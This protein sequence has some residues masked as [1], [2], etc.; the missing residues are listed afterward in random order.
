M[1]SAVSAVL[2]IGVVALSTGLTACGGGGDGGNSSVAAV[3]PDP[4]TLLDREATT[5]GNSV[6]TANGSYA[7]SPPNETTPNWAAATNVEA[8][9]GG[10]SQPGVVVSDALALESTPLTTTTTVAAFEAPPDAIS[11]WKFI[12]G[13][14]FPGAMGSLSQ[15]L[16]VGGGNAARIDYD[17]GCSTQTVALRAGE[18][19]GKYVQMTLASLTSL[20]VSDPTTAV[21][22]F[23]TRN[24]QGVVNPMVRVED[25]T[26]QTLQL[27]ARGRTVESVSGETWQRVHLPI[28]SSSL[29]WGGAN[30]GILHSPIRRISM[31]VADLPQRQPAGWVEFDN[32]S[33]VQNP[34]YDFE[35]KPSAP[36]AAG[37]FYP[38]YVGRLAINTYTGSSAALEK[39]RAAGITVV[40]RDLFWSTIEKDGIYDFSQYNAFA[41]AAKS[42]GMSV[43]WILDYGHPSYG[44]GAPITDT[45]RA[46]FV[47]F[48]KAAALN[49]KGRNVVGFE[50]WNEPNINQFWATPDPVAYAKLFNAAAS[51]IRSVDTS[52]KI[53]SGGT[54]SVDVNYSIAFAS[55]VQANLLDAFGVHPYSKPAPE[56]FANAYAPLKNALVSKGVAKPI[57]STEWG[58]SSFGDFDATKY[59]DGAALAARER[60]AV[61]TL[62]R[63]LTD[64]AMNTPF[65]N[66]YALT[67]Y[68]TNPLHREDNFGVLTKDGSDKPAIQALRTLYGVQS[69][70]TFKGY[71]PDVPPNLHVLRWESA[72]DIVFAI[73]SDTTGQKVNVTL[74]NTTQSAVWWNSTPA[75]SISTG[76]G[77]IIS[78]EEKSGPMFV[79]IPR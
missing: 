49:F 7:S 53:I 45:A 43:L 35:V 48:A 25:S 61:L 39:A 47:N 12:L 34:I 13:I 74:P 75:S 14:E 17:L 57:W 38:T 19:C 9:S 22:S 40:R 77:K 66:I 10:A 31:G 62:R 51:A 68:G 73:W 50:V 63:V 20:A 56:L 18:S 79:T 59:G 46:A 24:P 21:L 37:T 32:L 23:D 41:D 11:G 28:G 26:G 16:G 29:H 3:A 44:G 33:V 30:D 69:G 67:D 72:K 4:R 5:Q 58:Y 42:M 6:A 70:R 71:L 60:Q 64:L 27:Y 15:S 76:Y 36:V 55:N 65:L 1:R 54:A 2:S 52:T 8:S 78:L